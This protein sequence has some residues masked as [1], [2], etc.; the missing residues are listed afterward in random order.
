MI[1]FNYQTPVRIRH[2]RLLKSFLQDIIRSEKYTPGPLSFV[3]CTDDFL[4]QINQQYLNHHDY[5]DII[6]FNLSEEKGTVSGEMYISIDR[7]KDNAKRFKVPASTELHRVMFHGILHLCGYNDK[8]NKQ[9]VQMREREDHYLKLYAK[10]S[11]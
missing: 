7:I 9:V 5:T 10:R 1:Q 4:L 3:F 11:T 6:T 8:T 2:I